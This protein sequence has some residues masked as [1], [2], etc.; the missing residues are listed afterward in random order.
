MN[1]SKYNPNIETGPPLNIEKYALM[2]KSRYDKS[3]VKTL[4]TKIASEVD[5]Q[6]SKF[7]EM[8]IDTTDLAKY[9]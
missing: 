9:N 6:N 1:I 4:M 2:N 5:S 3:I 8:A 7:K